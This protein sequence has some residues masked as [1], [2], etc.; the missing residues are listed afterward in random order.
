MSKAL[1]TALAVLN[2]Y[3]AVVPTGEKIIKVVI[4]AVLMAAAL[5]AIDVVLILR[6][7]QAKQNKNN[8]TD[9][10]N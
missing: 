1:C 8:K 9:D 2:G 10:K 6:R 5:I 4:P 7:A 3:F